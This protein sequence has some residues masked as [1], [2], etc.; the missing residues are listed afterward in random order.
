[1]EEKGQND[2]SSDS[3]LGGVSPTL[4]SRGDEPA[5]A[6]EGDPTPPPREVLRNAVDAVYGVTD[7]D[8]DEWEQF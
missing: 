7:E 4:N 2:D 8:D 6:P 1:M 3:I 5:S